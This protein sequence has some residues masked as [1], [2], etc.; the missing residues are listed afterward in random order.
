GLL[1]LG[2][3]MKSPAVIKGSTIKLHVFDA[4]GGEL[5]G[6]AF[7]S[8][9]PDIASVDS[10]TGVVTGIERGYATITTQSSDGRS[11][12]EFITVFSIDSGS[13]IKG[14]GKIEVDNSGVI[15]LTGN[16]SILRKKNFSSSAE[17]FAGQLGVGGR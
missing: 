8:D 16:N 1:I 9:S 13:G 3:N 6:L 11:G 15:Y 7:Q 5:S 2:D 10:Q 14:D 4:K 17:L 12:S